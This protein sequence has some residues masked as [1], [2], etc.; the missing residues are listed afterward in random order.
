MTHRSTRWGLALA[1]A[2]ALG[3]GT[4]AQKD[5]PVE[6]QLQAA[7][8]K[9]MVDG[10]LKGAIETYKKVVAQAGSNRALAAQ[11]L[12]RMAECHTKL[13]DDQARQAYERLVRDYGDM[14]EA[15]TARARIGTTGATTAR[16]AAATDRIVKAGRGHHVG[17][18]PGVAGWPV[19]LVHGLCTTRAT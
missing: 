6:K 7:I 19:H 11:A 18:R 5:A 13:G 3:V 16:T 15:K 2:V 17:Q 9:E 8:H 12:L 14:P 10:D 1:L 4:A